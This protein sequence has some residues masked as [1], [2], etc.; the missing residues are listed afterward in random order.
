MANT[1]RRNLHSDAD[2]VPNVEVYTMPQRIGFIRQD[3]N[4]DRLLNTDAVLFHHAH[5]QNQNESAASRCGIC[6]KHLDS[7]LSTIVAPPL[8]EKDEVVQSD[9]T[10]QEGSTSPS[11]TDEQYWNV[12]GYLPPA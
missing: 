12:G 1:Q 9:R 7:L 5:K 10:D 4:G 8:D 6:K 2:R 3:E 11:S